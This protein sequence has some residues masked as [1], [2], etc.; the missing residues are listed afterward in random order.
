MNDLDYDCLS[1]SIDRQGKTNNI[2]N[3]LD[4]NIQSVVANPY[5]LMKASLL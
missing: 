1:W 4:R 2:I 5:R 3:E